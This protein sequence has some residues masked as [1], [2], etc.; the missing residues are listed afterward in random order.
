MNPK[1][2]AL[3][4]MHLLIVATHAMQN[5]GKDAYLIDGGTLYGNM[6]DCKTRC[7]CGRGSGRH[8]LQDKMSVFHAFSKHVNFTR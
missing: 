2:G 7:Y 6:E 4:F 1:L 3:F 5:C 8:V